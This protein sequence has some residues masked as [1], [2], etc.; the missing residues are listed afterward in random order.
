VK[1][2][3]FSGE[4]FSEYF[5][6]KLLWSDPMLKPLLDPDGAEAAYK[7]ASAVVRSAQRAL[8]DREQARSTFQLLLQPL[9]GLLGWRLGERSKVATEEAEEEGG[10]PLLASDGGRPV[11][12]AVF[13][14]PASS[15]TPHRPACTAG[16][17]RPCRW[18]ACSA[19]RG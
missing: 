5:C 12:R 16:S 17:H 13:L 9:A 6:T 3:T 15:S 14:P 2:V 1:Q 7:G 8:R 4:G 18:P 11:A 19:R 10:V